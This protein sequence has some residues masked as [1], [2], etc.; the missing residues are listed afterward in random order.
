VLPGLL[1]RGKHRRYSLCSTFIFVTET[2]TQEDG[3]GRRPGKPDD[4]H[5]YDKSNQN[6]WLRTN[7]A[8]SNPWFVLQCCQVLFTYTPFYKHTSKTDFN[9]ST[10]FVWKY[11]ITFFDEM[12]YTVILYKN[13]RNTFI[14]LI[15]MS[16]KLLRL[17]SWQSN[18]SFYR[19]C[20]NRWNVSN[21]S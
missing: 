6:R 4:H 21:V 1:P 20:Q 12:Y 8:A 11:N 17:M 13:T 16:I 5:S 10:R 18:T 19:L 2:Y 7:H 3:Q 9:E 14:M 15:Y